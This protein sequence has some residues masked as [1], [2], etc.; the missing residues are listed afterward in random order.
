MN[1]VRDLLCWRRRYTHH[2]SGLPEAPRPR[3]Y[4]ELATFL[5]SAGEDFAKHR[6]AIVRR[7]GEDGNTYCRD[8]LSTTPSTPSVEFLLCYDAQKRTLLVFI[9][10][11]CNL[12]APG[13]SSV[14]AVLSDS[15]LTSKTIYQ[16]FDPIYNE[17]LEFS[18]LS[19]CAICNCTLYLQVYTHWEELWS[20]GG[21]F[22]GSVSLSLKDPD[23]YWSLESR[24]I[25]SCCREIVQMS[26]LYT[27]I[28][29]IRRDDAAKCPSPPGSISIIFVTIC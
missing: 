18:G 10:R 28:I 15:S 6:G 20:S 13:G 4:S 7:T 16:P 19:L 24:A 27:C 8:E 1:V 12:S 14:K 11:I 5:Q 21:E 29:I 17:P 25:D 9:R 22:I 2:N 3:Q 26:Y 23:L